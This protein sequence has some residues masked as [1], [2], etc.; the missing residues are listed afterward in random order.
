MRA[1]QL[2]EGVIWFF[3]VSCTLRRCI[4]RVLFKAKVMLIELRCQ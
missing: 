4:A 1:I 2:T 3:M